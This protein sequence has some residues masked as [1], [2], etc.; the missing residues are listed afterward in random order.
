MVKLNGCKFVSD[1]SNPHHPLAVQRDAKV[2]TFVASNNVHAMG[3]GTD[4]TYYMI[5]E[6]TPIS[7]QGPASS[8]V[9]NATADAFEMIKGIENKDK[10]KQI[11]R[12]FI[13]WNAR[14][15]TRDTD[16]DE[17]SFIMYAMDSLVQYGVCEESTWAYDTN[18][19]FAQPN[20]LAYKEGD[21]NTL[22]IDNFYKIR[23]LDAYRVQDVEAAVRANHPVIFG[24][25][26]NQ[27]F[28]NFSGG[29]NAF[30]EPTNY[31]GR[32]AMVVVGV[33]TK[34]NKKEFCV[35]NSWSENWGNSGHAWISQ[36]YLCSHYTED[37]YVPTLMPDL[38][39]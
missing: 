32:H 23:T 15:Y 5:P 3:A 13:Y 7:D 8:C 35:R 11:S 34:N 33:R 12:L 6:Y 27:D 19:I 30:P 29:D 25:A 1:H 36:E 20:I 28:I 26:V 39:K 38:L 10:V 22:K 2:E 14:L 24:T 18:K 37:L 17:G 4:P 31:V 16:K 9:A 21:D